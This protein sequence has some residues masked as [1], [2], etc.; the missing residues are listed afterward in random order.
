[1]IR[2]LAGVAVAALAAM[3]ARRGWLGFVVVARR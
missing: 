1:M 3:G 2:H